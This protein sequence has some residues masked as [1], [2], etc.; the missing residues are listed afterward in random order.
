[1]AD[2]TFDFTGRTV[3]VTGA[4]RG[5]GRAVGEHF[6]NAGATVYL[7]DSDAA[8]VR[9]AEDETGATGLVADVSDTA[10]VT[11]VMDRVVAAAG[12]IDVLVNN[13]GILRDGVL[14]KLSDDD[15]EA[16]M[17]VHAGGTFRFT[18]A[19]VPHLRR[20]GGGRIINVTS[21][22]GLRGNPGQ[23]NYAMAKAGIIGFTK[24]AAKELARFGITVN[25][26]SPNARTRMT[27]SIPADTLARLT[28]EIPMGRFADPAEIAGAVAF[29]ASEEASYITGVVLPVDG[30]ISL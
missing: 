26:I 20:Q 10:Q 29:L 19:A 28:A 16:V 24:T 22:T 3:V 25:A 17:A 14:W 21:Y 11:G 6:H 1:M 30:G 2:L 27:A 12:R 7:V 23:S 15:Y 18:R 4:A 8:A 5:V 9:A 13:A